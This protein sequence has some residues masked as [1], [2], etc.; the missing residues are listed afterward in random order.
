TG[1]AGSGGSGAGGGDR[2]GT[3]GSTG[4]GGTGGSTGGDFKC[5]GS[6]TATTAAQFCAAWSKAC[7]YNFADGYFTDAAQC[8]STW[9]AASK[10]GKTCRLEH[11]CEAL[12][13][14]GEVMAYHCGQAALAADGMP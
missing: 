11:L 3:G 12:N 14:A 10:S 5:P 9:T 6:A 4:T 13:P 7:P 1:E 2:G 8:T